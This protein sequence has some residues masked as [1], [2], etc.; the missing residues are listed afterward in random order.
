M[1]LP[2]TIAGFPLREATPGIIKLAVL[3]GKQIASTPDY[4]MYDYDGKIV[5]VDRTKP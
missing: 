4:A 1:P 5:V 3:L 2:D